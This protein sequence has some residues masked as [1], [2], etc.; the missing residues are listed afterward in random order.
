MPDLWR[1]GYRFEFRP[2]LL[3]FKVSHTTGASR[4]TRSAGKAKVG[5]VYSN[6]G[7]NAGCVG[8]PLTT[9]A[10]TMRY[11]F[12]FIIL[13]QQTNVEQSPASCYDVRECEV[14]EICSP[15]HHT[16][17]CHWMMS[18]IRRSQVSLPV[19]Q[20]P[21]ICTNPLLHHIW[22]HETSDAV[23][24]YESS[25]NKTEHIALSHA[26]TAQLLLHRQVVLP[27]LYVHRFVRRET[28]L[29]LL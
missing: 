4:P 15:P 18:S 28:V 20:S 19:N 10:I 11:K 6:C 23:H 3:C 26:E 21:P 9:R 14:E 2:G 27:S 16:S 22:S 7:W 24:G 8:Y 17:N 5:M 12:T 13:T 1:G 25:R 29:T